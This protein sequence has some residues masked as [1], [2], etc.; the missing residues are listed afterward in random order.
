MPF[1]KKIFS[2]H[3]FIYQDWNFIEEHG[4]Y[5]PA[6]KRQF[7]IDYHCNRRISKSVIRAG[8]KI[9]KAKELLARGEKTADVSRK[10]GYNNVPALYRYFKK[11]TGETIGQFKKRI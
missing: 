11:R 3:D 5:L 2:I 10:V 8:K 1:K 6:K 7:R 4:L 9:E